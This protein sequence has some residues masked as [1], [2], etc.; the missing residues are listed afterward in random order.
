MPIQS[1]FSNFL[2]INELDIDNASIEQ[3]CLDLKKQSKGL[4]VSNEG[5]WHSEYLNTSAPQLK[6]LFD[7]IQIR[8][9][10][11]HKQLGFKD[12]HYQ[13]IQAAWANINQDNTFNK[14]HSHPGSFFSGCY[15]IKAE[16]Q[17][18]DIEFLNPLVAHPYTIPTEVVEE[19]NFYN[20]E[21][22]RHPAEAGKL[23]I[24][25]PWLLHYTQPNH[26][27][28]DRISIAFNSQIIAR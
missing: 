15:Y 8:L 27:G 25:P 11:L 23:L 2:S 16:P 19:Y 1:I 26:S 24:F 10:D 3:Y 14:P 22:W 21:K 20:S 4:L 28:H 12:N 5:G 6:P 18:G 17:A 7:A 13:V 9:N